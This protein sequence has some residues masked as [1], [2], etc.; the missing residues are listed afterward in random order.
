MRQRTDWV[1]YGKGI[2][3]ILVVYGHLLSSGYHAHLNIQ[4][5]F[6][7]LSDSIIYSFHMPFFFFLTGQFVE[8]SFQKRGAYVFLSNKIRYIAYPYLIWS[9][10]QTSIELL[11]AGHTHRGIGISDILAIPYR[12]WSQFWF[13]YA[14]TL[15]YIAYSIFNKLGRYST[16]VMALSA[17]VLFFYPIKTEIAALHD[18]SIE[19]L[20]FVSGILTKRHFTNP[21][22]NSIPTMVTCA[23]FIVLVGS[24][25]FIFTTQIEPVR[26]TNGSHPFYFLYLSTLGILSGTGLS[27]L[28]AR[29]DC[30]RFI[31]VLGVHSLPIYLVHML[32]GVGAR[33]ILLK[34]FHIN[35]PVIHLGVGTLVGLLAPITIYQLSLML[36][37]PYLFHLK[38]NQ[39]T[40]YAVVNN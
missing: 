19:F 40:A 20:F 22:K 25:Y 24:G 35:N 6:F 34:L 27:Q 23:L 5:H 28:L 11:L 36:H 26:L 2:G 13:L 30:C 21:G 10:L 33:I 38:N 8:Q 1:D 32:A 37:F 18:F 31:K 4:E 14:L 9:L 17:I 29:K 12:P 3:I 7:A 39:S 15:M 16:A